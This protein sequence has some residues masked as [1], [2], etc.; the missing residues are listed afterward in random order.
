MN[1]AMF[2][3][4]TF[5][6]KFEIWKFDFNSKKESMV[7]EYEVP[8]QEDTR[9]KLKL[10]MFVRRGHDVAQWGEE[11]DETEVLNNRFVQLCYGAHKVATGAKIEIRQIQKFENCLY[12]QAVRTQEICTRFISAEDL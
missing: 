2:F 8:S 6:D 12:S 3:I 10:V 4:K 5:N 7:S 11:Q 1:N 9:L